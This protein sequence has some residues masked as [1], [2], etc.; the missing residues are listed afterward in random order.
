MTLPEK[1]FRTALKLKKIKKEAMPTRLDTKINS[2]KSEHVQSMAPKGGRD[3]DVASDGESTDKELDKLMLELDLDSV[4]TLPGH[5]YSPFPSCSLALISNSIFDHTLPSLFMIDPHP[6]APHA[7]SHFKN[8]Y[9]PNTDAYYYDSQGPCVFSPTKT[10]RKQK[11]TSDRNESSYYTTK[12]TDDSKMSEHMSFDIEKFKRELK[13]LGAG[14]DCFTS[15]R[16]MADSEAFIGDLLDRF[17]STESLESVQKIKTLKKDSVSKPQRRCVKIEESASIDNETM[18]RIS[19]EGSIASSDTSSVSSSC[20]TKRSYDDALGVNSARKANSRSAN[21]NLRRASS[22]SAPAGEA[23]PEAKSDVKPDVKPKKGIKI[24]PQYQV[25]RR[26]LPRKSREI[27][28]QWFDDH[29]A[30]PYPEDVDREEL[31]NATGLTAKQI[32]HWFTNRRKRDT[33]WRAKYL[34]RGRGRRPKDAGKQ[35]LAMAMAMANNDKEA[36]KAHCPR[37]SPSRCTPYATR[38]KKKQPDDSGMIKSERSFSACSST[39][40]TS[41]RSV[42]GTRFSE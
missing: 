15:E 22:V 12:R 9:Q 26:K 39:S 34:F 16:V 1:F 24:P 31:M 37:L 10:L 25:K 20:G 8:F 35:A 42:L 14:M 21:Y 11:L 4:V 6:T 17:S 3:C 30:N 7:D 19:S 5:T 28:A 33:K 38:S 23:K 13:E 40:T 27:L 41:I 2:P 29:I 18:R 36:S 32:H